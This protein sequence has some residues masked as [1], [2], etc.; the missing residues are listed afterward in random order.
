MYDI[1]RLRE[2][3]ERIA[4]LAAT[5]QP[6]ASIIVPPRSAARG[7]PAVVAGSFNPPTDAHLS[8]YEGALGQGD[9]DVVWF[10]LAVQTVDKEHVTGASLEDRLCMLAEL[11]NLH[12]EIGVVLCNRGLYVEQA[13]ALRSAIVAPQQELVF[14]V[15]YD[16]IQ[17][18]LDPRY[19]ADREASLARL[20]SLG[21]FLVAERNG[22]G[23]AALGEL[24]GNEENQPYRQR[25]AALTTLPADHD[26]ALSSTSVRTA[27][28][29][30]SDLEAEATSVPRSVRAFLDETGVY[31]APTVLSNGESIDRYALRQRLLEIF[32][33]EQDTAFSAEE[34]HAAIT[35]AKEE[36]ARGT[37]L[38]RNLV[39]RESDLQA[40]RTHLTI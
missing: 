10:S 35:L 3:H 15:G 33:A 38:R 7:N 4:D 36:S 1:Q 9:I 14:A 32:L 19:Y 29:R 5:A 12:P 26:P 30:A 18:I 13:E 8:L 16:K 21:R 24:L 34:F 28:V 39:Q 20:F 31:A 27:Y 40:I 11:A 23:N 17:Q 25:I 2:W 6:R 37:D 22:Y